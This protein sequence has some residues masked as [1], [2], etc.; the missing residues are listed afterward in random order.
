LSKKLLTRRIRTV[1]FLYDGQLSTRQ[2]TDHSGTVTDSYTY[3]A[4]GNLL[5][6]DGDTENNFLYTG[7]QYD[8]N[9]GSYYLRARYY[10]QGV[11]R[12]TTVDPWKGN[13]FEPVTLHRYLYAGANPVMNVDPSGEAFGNIT[14]LMTAMTIGAVVNSITTGMLNINTYQHDPEQFWKDIGVSAAIGAVS[15][16]AG[17]KIFHGV[18]SVMLKLFGATLRPILQAAM[19]GGWTSFTAQTLSEISDFYFNDTELTG[20]IVCGGTV[21]IVKSSFGGFVT[22]G[23]LVKF[24]IFKPTTVKYELSRKD[25]LA[26]IPFYGLTGYVQKFSALGSAGIAGGSLFGNILAAIVGDWEGRVCGHDQ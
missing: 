25:G 8:P 23:A 14:E 3:D 18:S 11:G 16:P 10:D 6:Q 21:R 9:L 15:V 26:P 22:G 7:E 4:F 2:L 5:A 20:S 17:V 24:K 13:Q 1:A 12:F 19:I